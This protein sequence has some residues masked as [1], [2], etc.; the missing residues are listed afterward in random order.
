MLNYIWISLETLENI[1]NSFSLWGLRDC[2]EW[3]FWEDPSSIERPP[4]DF[5][6]K[7]R[8]RLGVKRKSARHR[9]RERERERKKARGRER[10]WDDEKTRNK[11]EK[12]KNKRKVRWWLGIDLRFTIYS[13]NNTRELGYFDT[14][15][16]RVFIVLSWITYGWVWILYIALKIAL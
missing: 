10:E 5:G 6:S 8:R 15:V 1:L 11:K 14:I 9:D 12:K 7:P 16:L 2:W 13:F 3:S 4:R